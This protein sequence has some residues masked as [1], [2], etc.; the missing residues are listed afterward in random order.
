MANEHDALREQFLVRMAAEPMPDY[1]DDPGV[2]VRVGKLLSEQ[3]DK[4]TNGT[5]IRFTCAEGR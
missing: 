2:R 3:I 1:S 4:G 5:K